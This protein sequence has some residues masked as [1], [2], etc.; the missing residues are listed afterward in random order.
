MAIELTQ[1][2]KEILAADGHLLV[3]G[4]P[5]SGKT[6]ISILKAQ[7]LVNEGLQNAQ[8]VLFLSFARA[9]VSRVLEAIAAEE[10][11]T[12]DVK[13]YIEV[14][15]YHAFC[16]RLIKTHGYLLGLPRR[17]VI[18]APPNEGV[19]LSDIRNQYKSDYKLNPEEWQQKKKLEYDERRRLAFEDGL[20]CFNLFAEI[21]GELLHRSNKIRCLISNAYPVII[22]D[23]FQDTASDQWCFIQALGR[24][25]ILLALADPEQRIFDFIG[26]DPE[27]L[28]HFENEF[29]PSKFDL[30]D[31]NHR[32]KGTDLALFG[33]DI[34]KGKFT[35]ESYIGVY[36][37]VFEPNQN[38][39]ITK[40]ITETLKAR[41]RLL[42]D[43]PKDWSLAI[44]VP[45]KRMTRVVSEAFR[46]PPAKLPKIEHNATVDMEAAILAAEIIAYLLQSY[47]R[48]GDVATFVNL[49]CGYFRGKGGDTPSKTSLQVAA[50]IFT[51]FQ[52]AIECRELG[53]AAPK[54]SIFLP[55][56]T[57][58]NTTNDLVLTGDPDSDW[59]TVRKHLDAADCWRL[60]EI[61][62][63]V[64]NIRLL[65]RGTQLRESLSQN[66]RDTGRYSDALNIVQQAFVQEH[67]STQVRPESGV[68]VMNMHKAKG[69]QFDEVIIFEGPPRIARRKIVAN[70]DRI[71]RG[72]IRD[73]VDEQTRQNFRVSITR[74][75]RRTI[76]LTPEA[77][78]CVLLI[79]QYD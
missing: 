60:N 13:R 14:D 45:T 76:I 34:L 18:M 26:A 21:V 28:Q 46:E 31:E 3:Q 17:L 58:Y 2:Q 30:S 48:Q 25:S 70:P 42:V 62:S 44:L 69:K 43:G 9:T 29:K 22:L 63:E 53:K 10:E 20:V 11:I 66:W 1:M 35:K 61:A 54:K 16:W 4:G 78:P 67:F 64:R 7:K 74:A 38:Q 55:I 52:K 49:I 41:K 50:Q 75:K 5:G 12:H 47:G 39:A 33:N 24:D 32:S 77:D 36:I 40:V 19:A 37:E 15:T 71:V 59:T 51:A 73:N 65:D 6:T 79:P 23:E 27:R 56:E 68:V 72:N 8:R 57:A